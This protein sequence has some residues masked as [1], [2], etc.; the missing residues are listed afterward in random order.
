MT[1][2]LS[3]NIKIDGR[4]YP[5]KVDREN[6]EKHRK[7]AKIIND[8]VLQYRQKYVNNDTQD[9]LAMAAFQFVLKAL[10]LEEKVDRSPLFDELKQ[11]DEELGDYL[12]SKE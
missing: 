4:S 5:L 11:L 8:I 3:I 1:E 10:D 2:K 6:E 7:A 9:F 12:S